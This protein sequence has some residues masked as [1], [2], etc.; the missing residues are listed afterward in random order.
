M[1]PAKKTR[2]LW[3]FASLSGLMVIMWVVSHF[4]VISISARWNYRGSTIASRYGRLEVFWFTHYSPV[5]RVETKFNSYAELDRLWG[6]KG[7][8]L[9]S[10]Q[11]TLLGRAPEVFYSRGQAP[12][13]T[14]RPSNLRL[15]FWLL[16]LL[17]L[18]A[19]AVLRWLDR[20]RAR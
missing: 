20:R 19:A 3:P 13:I 18:A 14:L 7:F 6:S 12:L 5:L 8:S 1:S 11:H 10:F 17:P 15:P 2:L 9:P 16:F 4:W